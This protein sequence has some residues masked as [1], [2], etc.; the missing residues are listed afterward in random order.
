MDTQTVAVLVL[1]DS[2]QLRIVSDAPLIAG[3]QIIAKWITDGTV[4]CFDGEG[5]KQ[6]DGFRIDSRLASFTGFMCINAAQI[7]H[8]GLQTER[9]LK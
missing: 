8:F 5:E 9:K 2:R 7:V 1:A 4:V 3:V 6:V